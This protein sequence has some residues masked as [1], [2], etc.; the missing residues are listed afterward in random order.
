M[1]RDMFNRETIMELI[2]QNRKLPKLHS[3][4]T[5]P[6]SWTSWKGALNDSQGPWVSSHAHW[7]SW[8]CI[9][10]WSTLLLCSKWNNYLNSFTI[11]CDSWFS[12]LWIRHQDP[13]NIWS[14][15]QPP[16]ASPGNKNKHSL[17]HL[18]SEMETGVCPEPQCLFCTYRVFCSYRNKTKYWGFSY[19][20][21]SACINLI[22][23]WT[24][25]CQ[26]V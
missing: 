21:S 12:I 14:P 7:Q 9:S 15:N 6:S 16:A 3:L 18:G 26:N 2:N 19:S 23:L 11:L 5:S 8:Q 22:Y 24:I 17:G 20:H 10:L 13:G 4:V 25:L 1:G